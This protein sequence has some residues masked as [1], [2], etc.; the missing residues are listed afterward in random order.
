[1][2]KKLSLAIKQ[3][4]IILIVAAALG[5]VVNFFH[6]KQVRIAAR[7]PS[8]KFAPDTMLAQDLP[9]VTIQPDMQDAAETSE[10]I[11]EP[12]FITTAQ[13][14]QL[15]ATEM[16]VLLDSRSAL[17]FEHSH[18][19]GARNLPYPNFSG[20]QTELDSLPR[21]L[22]LV[23]YCDGPP[24]QQAESL[25]FELIRSGFELVAV[26]FDGLEGWK[27]AGYEIEG[28]EA[29]KNED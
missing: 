28:K 15:I 20:Y 2:R 11:V 18:I 25:A 16:A 24:C 27:Q 19:Y 3:A 8:L 5:V 17:E 13:L 10:E 4:V 29:K 26:Y 7:R 22:W 9:G 14:L 12:L 1:M 21:D 23:C 6:P